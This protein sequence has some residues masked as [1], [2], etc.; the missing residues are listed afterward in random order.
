MVV[1]DN[2]IN[3]LMVTNMLE[4]F[5]VD[6]DFY[7]SG[8]EA[9][10]GAGKAGYALV[11][12]DYLMPGMD[13]VETTRR[14][15]ALE[16]FGDVPVIA[17]SG[18]TDDEIRQKFEEAGADDL[19]GK[20]VSTESITSILIK[21]GIS[22]EETLRAK[23]EESG[24][25]SE[26]QEP[27]GNGSGETLSLKSLLGGIEGLDYESGLKNCV[28]IEKNYFYVI[29]AGIGN[30]SNCRRLMEQYFAAHHIG[31]PAG[32]EEG[33]DPAAHSVT[34]KQLRLALHSLKSIYLNIGIASTS[35][36]ASKYE[37]AVK[38]LYD[39]EEDKYGY[40]D[41]ASNER[42]RAMYL[43]S[44]G[45]LE[46]LDRAV[47]SYD[48]YLKN[49]LL[50]TTSEGEKMDAEEFGVLVEKAIADTKLFDIDSITADIEKLAGAGVSDKEKELLAEA[51]D[52]TGSFD[53]DRILDILLKMGRGE[54]R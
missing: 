6:S 42:I 52:A 30:I 5:G 16:G 3:G 36:E 48:E 43:E 11:L 53:Y 22:D 37:K 23:L 44:E 41:D 51:M 21:Y 7:L 14:L 31:E 54:A 18:D 27:R 15:K 46:K 33:I 24:E 45:L 4:H 39:E 34:M 49:R 8:E 10:E 12:M 20:P 40:L 47:A 2:E 28:G 13:G 9:L 29:K 19:I 50:L 32:A 38:S 26:A 17:L 35:A 1:D 25:K